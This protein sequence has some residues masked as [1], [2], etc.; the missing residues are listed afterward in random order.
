MRIDSVD[1]DGTYCIFCN[2][3]EFELLADGIDTIIDEYEGTSI[4][5]DQWPLIKRMEKEFREV[6]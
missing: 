6:E 4:Y 2:Q 5:K 3:Q 1:M